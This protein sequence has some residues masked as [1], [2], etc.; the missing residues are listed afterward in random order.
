MISGKSR[1]DVGFMELRIRRQGI[2]R[3]KNWEVTGRKNI[4]VMC[5]QKIISN[6][7]VKGIKD[8]NIS[9]WI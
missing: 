3:L 9:Y 2:E 6:L 4:V 7:L 1:N 8:E 5:K